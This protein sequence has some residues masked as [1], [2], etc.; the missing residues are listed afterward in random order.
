MELVMK[1]LSLRT[2]PE[3]TFQPWQRVW[4]AWPSDHIATYMYKNLKAGASLSCAC[5][6]TWGTQSGIICMCT[7]QKLIT[8]PSQI[9]YKSRVPTSLRFISCEGGLEHPIET[10]IDKFQFQ[11]TTITLCLQDHLRNRNH[12]EL[13][14]SLCRQATLVEG[15]AWAIHVFIVQAWTLSSWSSLHT[16]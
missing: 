6:N 10:S 7:N 11:V 13:H 14:F 3:D 8:L 12:C 16:L 9:T 2:T 5:T 4:T 1:A 15:V